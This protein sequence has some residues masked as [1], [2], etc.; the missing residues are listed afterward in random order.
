MVIVLGG[1][2]TTLRGDCQEDCV[3]HGKGAYLHTGSVKGFVGYRVNRQLDGGAE[4]SWV[5]TTDKAGEDIRSTFILGTVQFRP[6]ASRGLFLNG[7]MG[8]A[9]LRDFAFAGTDAPPVTSKALALTYGIG[10]T[11]RQSERLGFQIFGAQHMAAV[12]DFESGGI[13]VENVVG[14]FWSVG[15]AIV[16]R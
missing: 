6:L 3:A 10:W 14:N 9:F 16:I 11:F 12:G 7:G 8:M 1:T 15:A 4:V 2:S 13:T 5:P